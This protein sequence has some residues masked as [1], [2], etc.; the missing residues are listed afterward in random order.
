MLFQAEAAECGLACVGMVAAAH[1][2]RVDLASLRRAFPITLRGATLR[3]VVS[4]ASALGMGSRAVRCELGEL[5]QLRTPAILHWNMNHFVVLTRINAKKAEI[6]DPARGRLR[7]RLS[8]VSRHFTGVALELTPTA[9]FEK[10]R[11]TNS[12]S[13]LGLLNIGQTARGAIVQAFALSLFLQVFVLLSPYYMQLVIDEAILK[14]DLSLLAAIALGFGAL[15]VFET[16]TALVRGLVFQFLSS[17]LSFDMQ[18]SL[19][20]HMIRLPLPYFHRRHI[21]DIQQRFQSL[22]PIQHFLSSGAIV[23]LLDGLLAA[24][25][26][27]ILF[28]YSPQLAFVVMG[29]L[30]LYVLIR[31]ALLPLVKRL[32]AE[33]LIAQ[34]TEQSTFLETLRAMQNFKVAG[35]ESEREGLWRNLAINKLNAQIRLGNVNIGY[36]TLS[37]ALIDIGGVIVIFLAASTAIGGN[38]SIGAIIAFLAFKG[39]FD[40]RMMALIE[41]VI[42]FRLL[43]VHLDR[44]SDIALEQQEEDAATPGGGRELLGGLAVENLSFRY[45]PF[46]SE[47]LKDVSFKV[48]PGEFVAVAAPSGAGKSTLLRLIVG[49]YEQ[50][51]GEIYFDGL[52]SRKWGRGNLRR[53]L[54]VVMQ[55]DCLLAGSIEENIS[56][57][58]NNPDP[59]RI[60][61]A[62]RLASIHDDIEAMPMGYRSLVG[63]MGTSLSGGQLQR[64]VLARALYRRPKMLIMDEATSA[65]DV[66]TEERVN[67]ELRA[68]KITRIVVAHRPQTL[69]SADRILFLKDGRITPGDT[70]L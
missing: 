20:R 69:A 8:D 27:I 63:D 61:T 9:T 12:V 41:Q 39:Q 55:D 44:I 15:K 25:L 1:G 37:Q 14:A 22:M 45:S 21:G 10:K 43:D 38:M 24:L 42:Q 28:L 67:A 57:F 51:G 5:A 60:R 31:V 23:A 49:L 48:A 62:A 59:D 64:I 58:D 35:I 50:T 54:G 70:G 34:S 40:Q 46:E 52:E 32:S 13:L 18:A 29:I 30:I 16:L 11:N 2:H 6:L 3:D 66:E 56:L 53:Q 47:V 26:G 65:L 68:L 36:D 33:V 19:F 4:I 17:L 7:L